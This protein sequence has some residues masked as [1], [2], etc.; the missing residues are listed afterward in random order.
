M[1]LTIIIED[2]KQRFRTAFNGPSFRD[3]RDAAVDLLNGIPVFQDNKIPTCVRYSANQVW[4]KGKQV[5]NKPDIEVPRSEKLARV[6]GYD[7]KDIPIWKR[8]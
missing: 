5:K 4:E 8:L 1:K 2:D 7:D 3:L 6:V